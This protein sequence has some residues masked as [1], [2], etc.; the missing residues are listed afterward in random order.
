[1]VRTSIWVTFNEEI[2]ER[3]E[4]WKGGTTG[5]GCDIRTGETPEMTLRRMEKER[6]FE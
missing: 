6:K 2:G 3:V 1:M 5:C 4:T